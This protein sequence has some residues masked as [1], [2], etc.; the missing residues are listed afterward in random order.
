MKRFLEQELYAGSAPLDSIPVLT[1]LARERRWHTYEE[2]GRYKA[3]INDTTRWQP[4]ETIDLWPTLT[5][6]TYMPF[7]ASWDLDSLDVTPN[8]P[9]A[10]TRETRFVWEIDSL[11]LEDFLRP[12]DFDTLQVIADRVHSAV[13]DADLSKEVRVFG[14]LISATRL[15]RYGTRPRPLVPEEMEAISNVLLLAGDKGIWYYPMYSLRNW[16][17]PPIGK[18]DHHNP[19]LRWLTQT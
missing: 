14:E 2:I 6:M 3:S 17:H 13:R 10:I 16:G 7:D 12:Q 8:W 1:N 19:N 15:K 9:R 5:S 18:T 4:N 11:A